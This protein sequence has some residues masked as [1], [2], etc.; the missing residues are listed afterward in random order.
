MYERLSNLNSRSAGS[1]FRR[2]RNGSDWLGLAG[3]PLDVH[4][5]RVWTATAS[6]AAACRRFAI[7]STLIHIPCT[8][9]I[10]RARTTLFSAQSCMR[11]LS[12]RRI[13][14]ASVKTQTGA[15]PTL[16]NT[17]ARKASLCATTVPATISP[18]FAPFRVRRRIRP[19]MYQPELCPPGSSCT[20][21]PDRQHR[22]SL[23]LSSLLLW[24][25]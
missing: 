7:V 23:F 25:L 8:P 20:L 1:K 15:F 10:V 21:L 2:L 19:D 17:S 5:R 11:I 9:S 12:T 6:C 22:A 16:V 4:S 18:V 13:R 3:R 14:A 24:L